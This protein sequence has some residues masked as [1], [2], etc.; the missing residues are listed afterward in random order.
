MKIRGVIL[1]N[2]IHHPLHLLSLIFCDNK[3]GVHGSLMYM[4][5]ILYYFQQFIHHCSYI[6]T[7]LCK[8][9]SLQCKTMQT[10]F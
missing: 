8:L 5:H 6:Q 1:T 9:Y 3:S 2:S 4:M 7:P 10:M